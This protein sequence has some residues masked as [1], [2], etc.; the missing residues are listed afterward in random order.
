MPQMTGVLAF[1]DSRVVFRQARR[2]VGLRVEAETGWGD[3]GA[4]VRQS[5]CQ[6]RLGP[7]LDDAPP[8]YQSPRREVGF[9]FHFRNIHADGDYISD[10]AYPLAVEPGSMRQEDCNDHDDNTQ[11]NAFWTGADASI[12][13]AP[14]YL[15]DADNNT[16]HLAGLGFGSEMT[17]PM[18]SARCPE[19]QHSDTYSSEMGD[20][21]TSIFAAAAI[22]SPTS[23]MFA[24][25]DP[26][27]HLPQTPTELQTMPSIEL[28]MVST[29]SKP[30][31]QKKKRGRPRLFTASD[32]AGNQDDKSQVRRTLVHDTRR[33]CP[34]GLAPRTAGPTDRTP[35]NATARR[36]H[37][38]VIK[39]SLSRRLSKT[40]CTCFKHNTGH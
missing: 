7:E 5:L 11:P 40:R 10:A 3:E 30:L 28:A 22:E 39:Y 34:Q 4:G 31:K 35:E 15:F 25:I 16:G 36:P 29:F 26:S 6:P 23:A 13:I 24:G 33:L 32:E 17:F 21:P 1:E 37:V 38:I 20:A 19:V 8:A 9:L 2:R 18:T 27:H 14:E 12:P